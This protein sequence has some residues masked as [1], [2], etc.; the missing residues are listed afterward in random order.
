MLIA[1][2]T[3]LAP[4][5]DGTLQSAA[6]D[7]AER[8]ALF[9]DMASGEPAAYETQAAVLWDDR[10]LYIGFW[11]QEPYPVAELTE[12]GS[13]IF[14][15]NDVELFIDGGDCYYE[16]EVNALGT[17]YEMFFIW[18][19]AFHKFDQ[20]EYDVHRRHAYTFGG[21]FDRRPET[22]W[23]GNHP[24]GIRWALRDWSMA[25]LICK[26]SVQGTLNDPKTRSEGWRVEI[27]IPWT[28]LRVLS[29]EK[30]TPPTPGEVWKMFFGRFEKL[31]V[32]GNDVQAAWCLTPHGRYDTHIPEKFTEVCFKA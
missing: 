31:R 1:K 17:T 32:G 4:N 21:D 12:P 14:Q 15:E 20:S 3:A 22:F 8:S 7:A 16:F 24:R 6:W 19:D 25:G 30:S 2:K 10:N 13:L 11:V 28:S 23:D 9:V 27:A 26:T 18:K 29:G 5:L